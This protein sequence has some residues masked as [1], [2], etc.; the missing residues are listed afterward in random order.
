[1]KLQDLFEMPN[2]INKEMPVLKT[3]FRP[4]YSITTID[5]EFIIIGKYTISNI[6]YWVLLKTDKSFAVLGKIGSISDEVRLLVIAKLDLKPTLDLSWEKEF[7]IEAQNVIQVDG[8]EVLDASEKM[9]GFGSL[10]YKSLAKYGYVLIS[11]TTQYKGGLELW[12]KLA[13]TAS[14]DNLKV[15]IIQD[16]EPLMSGSEALN[17]NGTNYPDEKIWGSASVGP[18]E[19]LK[20]VLLVLKM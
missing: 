5:R 1:M 17:Y 2:Y 8:V 14:K 9:Q 18:E 13:K 11:D 4:S 6:E 15:H 7:D 3:N 10:F 16:G 12:K 19:S 20:H